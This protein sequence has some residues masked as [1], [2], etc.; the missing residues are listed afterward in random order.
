M[1]SDKRMITLRFLA[2][3]NDINFAGNVHGGTAM[4]WLDEAGYVCAT[5]WSSSYCVTA[6]VGDI[7]FHEPIP[8][9]HIVEI[10]ARIIHTGRTSMSVAVDLY[11]CHPNYCELSKAIHC[12]MIFVAVDDG[13]KPKP[14]PKWQPQSAADKKLEAY[15]IRVRKGRK[16]NEEAL[17]GLREGV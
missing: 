15:A 11:H 10:H 8:I 6:F 14:V 5:G 2:Q 12:I 13:H 9:G 16:A 4:K 7:N 17:A 1:T 3:P